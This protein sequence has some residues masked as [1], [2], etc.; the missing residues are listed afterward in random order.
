[1]SLI[2]GL[3]GQTGAGKTTVSRVFADNGFF[4]INCDE[5]TR[6]IVDSD[7]P[8]NRD[9]KTLFPDFFTDGRFD[10]KKAAA[11]LF[12]DREL[13]TR[14]NNA[15]FPHIDRLIKSVINAGRQD[16]NKFILLDAPTLFE[17]GIDR[18]CGVI[19]G[20]I[21]DKAKRI[22]RITARDGITE[23][24][25]AARISA[26]HDDVFFRENCDYVIE[27]SGDIKALEAAAKKMICEIKTKPEQ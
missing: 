3:T 14:Y 24:Q 8:A 21:A 15:I 7:E 26:Q 11:A 13:L 16:G 12:S 9:I 2:V 17:A 20:C 19:V 22:E 5:L 1:M 23:E 4:V 6:N 10:R 25:A 27:N 18:E